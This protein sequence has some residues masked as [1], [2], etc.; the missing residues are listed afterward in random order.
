MVNL[1]D[2]GALGTFPKLNDS[3]FR[4]SVPGVFSSTID[5]SIT[6]VVGRFNHCGSY[7]FA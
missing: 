6:T 7:C 1:Y 2:R 3:E 5:M 4:G